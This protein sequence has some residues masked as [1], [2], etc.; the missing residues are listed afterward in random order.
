MKITLKSKTLIGWGVEMYYLFDSIDNLKNELSKIEYFTEKDLLNGFSK[1]LADVGWDDECD[2][3]D[4]LQKENADFKKKYRR[5]IAGKD[6][7]ADFLKRYRKST[8]RKGDLI[9]E[10]S[11]SHVS[12]EYCMFYTSVNYWGGYAARHRKIAVI[13]AY[14][15]HNKKISKTS[16][17]EIVDLF[18]KIPM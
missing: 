5:P 13:A 1:P 3:F 10:I 2:I 6:E 14:E 18:K 15:K 17:C 9:V 8:V 12:V 11:I 16:F 7:N 4:K